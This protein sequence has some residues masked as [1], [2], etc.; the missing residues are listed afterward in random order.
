MTA[1]TAAGTTIRPARAADLADVEHLLREA[2]LP[3]DGVAEH[4]GNFVIAES[5]GRLIGVAGVEIAGENALLRSVA[6]DPEWRSHGTGRALVERIVAD[7][8]ARGIRGMY[9]LTTTA[10]RYFPSFGFTAVSR[11]TVPGGIRDTGEFRS[12]CPSS[13]VAMCRMCNEGP[14]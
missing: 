9:L 11:E 8:E 7:A 14:G 6:V 10:E 2:A 13:A 3:I 12:V 5:A 1:D 4:L